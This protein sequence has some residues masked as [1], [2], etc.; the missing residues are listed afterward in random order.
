MNLSTNACV[1]MKMYSSEGINKYFELGSQHC[2]HTSEMH[3]LQKL[4]HPNVVSLIDVVFF[5]N[6]PVLV[7]EHLD[8]GDLYRYIEAATFLTEPCAAA[9]LR[10]CLQGLAYVHRFFDLPPRYQA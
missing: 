2:S 1:A 3:I 7:L 4:T 9:V 5:E 10:P 6:C 8:G